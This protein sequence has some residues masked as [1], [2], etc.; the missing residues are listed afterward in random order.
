MLV[1]GLEFKKEKER[2]DKERKKSD[3][4][5]AMCGD[6]SVVKAGR[7]LLVKAS[8]DV[9]EMAALMIVMREMAKIIKW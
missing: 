9:E 3:H 2:K 1:F 5:K 6:E 4:T 8:P 7:L